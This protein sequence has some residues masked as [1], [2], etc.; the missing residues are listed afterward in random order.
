MFRTAAHAQLFLSKDFYANYRKR[1]SQPGTNRNKVQDGRVQE[2]IL[3]VDQKCPKPGRVYF[4][5]SFIHCFSEHLLN[6]CHVPELSS[7]NC[8]VESCQGIVI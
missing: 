8:V 2:Q 3:G 7:P 1:L 4:T 6:V 5:H